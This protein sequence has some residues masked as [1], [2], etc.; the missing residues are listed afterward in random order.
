MFFTHKWKHF[1]YIITLVFR[2]VC[3]TNDHTT[4]GG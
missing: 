3:N 4:L 1:K 2:Q